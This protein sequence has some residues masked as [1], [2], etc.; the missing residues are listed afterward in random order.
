MN[1][2]M[3][4]NNILAKLNAV[5]CALHA[6]K[7]E[8]NE[9]G[10]YNYR[11][12]GGILAALKPLLEKHA[13]AITCTDEL[14]F[15]EGRHYIK[16]TATLFDLE[17]GE[18]ICTAAFAREEENKKG[19]DQ[20][21]VTGASS[22]YARKY[23]L[24]GLLAIDDTPDSDTTNKGDGDKPAPRKGTAKP[25]PAPAA[26]PRAVESKPEE[27]MMEFATGKLTRRQYIT[28]VK[29]CALDQ[30]TKSGANARDAFIKNCAPTPAQIDQFDN[31]VFDY[32]M[33][34]PIPT[35]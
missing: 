27:E 15:L 30:P 9:F 19:S 8:Y 5:Q 10:K 7:T 13:L 26:Q 11:T 6:P 33:N 29:L 23:A 14:V 28:L 34:N 32:E 2:T 3:A 18:L 31:D 12:T 21:Q 16:A 35:K 4:K 22:T 25:K 1:E 24:N 20:S 17:S